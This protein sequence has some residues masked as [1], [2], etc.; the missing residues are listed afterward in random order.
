MSTTNHGGKRRHHVPLALTRDQI[1]EAREL[2]RQ[3]WGYKAMQRLFAVSRE[4][5]SR[6]VNGTRT[7][8]GFV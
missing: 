6:A 4:T 2:R 3:G 5:L 1:I 8:R 7:Y